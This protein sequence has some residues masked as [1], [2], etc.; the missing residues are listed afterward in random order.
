VLVF[1][2]DVFLAF[3]PEPTLEGQVS[4]LPAYLEAVSSVGHQR[5]RSAVMTQAMTLVCVLG[6][7]RCERALGAESCFMVVS[8]FA[9]SYGLALS[10]K[11]KCKLGLGKRFVRAIIS[12]D[13]ILNVVGIMGTLR[14][15]LY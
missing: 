5:T 7:Q 9:Q 14:A 13:R 12:N 4:L 10:V 3:R 11:Q 1:H 2:F 15:G 8:K 6:I